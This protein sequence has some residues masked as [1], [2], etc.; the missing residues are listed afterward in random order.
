MYI[1]I[2]YIMQKYQ[3]NKGNEIECNGHL[4][5]SLSRKDYQLNWFSERLVKCRNKKNT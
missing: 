4:C 3:R 2:A 5:I 1:L